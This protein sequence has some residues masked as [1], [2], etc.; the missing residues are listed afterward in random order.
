MIQNRLSDNDKWHQVDFVTAQ[1]LSGILTQGSPTSDKWVY[2]YTIG[3]SN[4][5][6]HFETVKDDQGQVVKYFGN[7]DRNTV[8]TN[9]FPRVSLVVSLYDI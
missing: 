4:D 3:T 5:G 7:I 1:N 8:A 6:V 2:T 9:Y